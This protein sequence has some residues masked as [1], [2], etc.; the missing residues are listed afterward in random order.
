MDAIVHGAS[1]GV[2]LLISITA[3]LIVF[4]S[5]ISLVNIM[6]GAV[7]WPGEGLLSLQ[8]ILGYLMAP[9]VWLIGIPAE[10]CVTAGGLMGT[11]TIL[12]EFIAYLQLLQLPQKALSPRSQL[13]MLYAMCGFANFGSL[14]IMIGGMGGVVPERRAEIVSLAI[15]SLI[16]GTL[17]TC[18]TG[19]VVGVLV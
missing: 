5:L 17:A 9:V 11:K 4:V 18:L 8:M 6:L 7:P 19:A 10:Q 12:N 16:A 14:G 13:L 15:K 2:K 1:E 3:M